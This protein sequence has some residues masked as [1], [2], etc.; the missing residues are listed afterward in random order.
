METETKE[1][2]ITEEIKELNDYL[3][4]DSRRYDTCIGGEE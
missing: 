3:Y 4:L 2:D 1:R